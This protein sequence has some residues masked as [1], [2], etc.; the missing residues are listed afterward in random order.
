MYSSGLITGRLDQRKKCVEVSFAASRDIFESDIKDMK[1]KL[2][3]WY[4]MERRVDI[5]TNVFSE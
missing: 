2:E 5:F 3:M 1:G 4:E